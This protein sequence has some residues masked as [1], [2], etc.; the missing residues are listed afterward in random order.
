MAAEGVA[1]SDANNPIKWNTFTGTIGS[2]SPIV[3]D[4]G[5]DD[6]VLGAQ[7]LLEYPSVNGRFQSVPVDDTP[8]APQ[9]GRTG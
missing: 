7:V 1:T 4:L 5:V 9:L 3:I 2:T 8:W 6:K